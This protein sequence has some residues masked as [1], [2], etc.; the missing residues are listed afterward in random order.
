M[1]A[2]SAELRVLRGAVASPEWRPGGQVEQPAEVRRVLDPRRSRLEQLEG[3]EGR[4]ADRGLEAEAGATRRNRRPC[5]L[6]SGPQANPAL[7]SR[8]VAAVRLTRRLLA[9]TVAS[10][11]GQ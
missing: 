10:Y 5:Q 2:G 4:C 7:P 1:A 6:S 3:P 8:R 11:L 9:G